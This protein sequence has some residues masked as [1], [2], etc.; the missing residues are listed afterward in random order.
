[1]IKKSTITT[2]AAGMLLLFLVTPAQA[3]SINKSVKIDAG[4]QADG[5]S[6][7]N[8][9]IAVGSG[10]TITGPLETVNGAIRID[11][12]AVV[13]DAETVNGSVKLG[14]GVKAQDIS[15][16]NG[17]IRIGERVTINGEI[18]IVNGKIDVDA[19]STVSKDVSNVNGE[20]EISGAEIAGGLSTVNGDVTLDEGAVLRG[21]LTIEKPG[22]VNWGNRNSRKPRII[23]GPGS[24][25]GGDIVAEREIELYISDSAEVG[26][27]SGVMSMDQAV[28]F[29][30]SRP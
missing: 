17:A 19:G 21:N 20:I 26:G 10:A 23:I 27:V 13:A 4:S 8:G 22:G 24:K 6:T 14:S 28:R 2:V 29:S 30:G 9:S 25:V 18:S 5:A 12:N 11:E 7:V 16:V 3:L 1:M 15:S